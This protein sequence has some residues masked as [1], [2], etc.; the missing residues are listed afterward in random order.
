MDFNIIVF[1][2]KELPQRNQLTNQSLSLYK[3]TSTGKSVSYIR[4][5]QKDSN[6]QVDG[7][8]AEVSKKRHAEIS[9]TN[10]LCNRNRS[11]VFWILDALRPKATGLDGNVILTGFLRIELQFW[12]CL[13]LR[14]STSR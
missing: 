3:K 9:T 14:Y 11:T 4:G 13:S 12:L 7:L 8:T 10:L 1:D 6:C 2:D 5:G